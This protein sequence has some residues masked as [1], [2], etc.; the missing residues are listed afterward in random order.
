MDPNIPLE[1]DS[2]QESHDAFF[3]QGNH[4]AFQGHFLMAKET[5]VRFVP[6]KD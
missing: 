4:A 5:R 1:N 6:R 2:T 3:S